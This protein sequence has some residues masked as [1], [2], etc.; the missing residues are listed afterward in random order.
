MAPLGLEGH[1]GY[2]RKWRCHYQLK[3]PPIKVSLATHGARACTHTHTHLHVYTCVYFP[4]GVKP[5]RASHIRWM[6]SRSV[7]PAVCSLPPPR[8]P[9]PRKKKAVETR[10]AKP[11]VAHTVC[12]RH[13]VHAKALQ[14]SKMESER[15]IINLQVSFLWERGEG[16]QRWSW[17]EK[18]LIFWSLDILPPHPLFSFLLTP[19]LQILS[20][21][22][23]FILYFSLI[24]CLVLY[25]FLNMWKTDC[26]NSSWP[27]LPLVSQRSN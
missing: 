25:L 14:S 4:Q 3:R 8:S 13:P 16:G 1:W 2:R 11:G 18:R 17:G 24:P 15:E 7:L 21:L 22:F 10:I 5:R 19:L 12:C 26:L 9:S 27:L 6:N 23:L 20:S